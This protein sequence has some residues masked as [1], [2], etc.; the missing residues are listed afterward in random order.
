V[1]EVL[2]PY[3]RARLARYLEAHWEEQEV[4]EV[5][6]R[7]T[8]ENEQE[9]RSK[10][11]TGLQA[12]ARTGLRTAGDVAAFALRLMD[13][14]RKSPGLKLLQGL[15]WEEGYR[16]GQLRGQVYE[17]V[18]AAIRRWRASGADVAIYSSGSELAQR[19][20]FQSTPH[21]DLTPHLKAFFDTAVGAKVEAASYTRIATALGRPSTEILFVSDVMLELKAARE[22]GMGIVL[23]MRPGNPPQ[24]Y[25]DTV[26]SITSLD[27]I[28]V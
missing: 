24:T 3:A 20:L 18:P 13:R 11:R 25:A 27:Q 16:V 9:S 23:S 22:A 2:F 19:L 10:A 14:D 28:D 7:L 21:G 1:H 15:I 4:T 26:E 5:R 12:E 8:E 17:D 6:R